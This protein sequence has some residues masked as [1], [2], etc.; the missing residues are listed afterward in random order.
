MHPDIT[1]AR[2]TVVDWLRLRLLGPGTSLLELSVEVLTRE[3]LSS[4]TPIPEDTR[5][6]MHA[7]VEAME[8]PPNSYCLDGDLH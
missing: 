1:R 7:C 2:K 8:E 5:E 6:T 3:V 4:P